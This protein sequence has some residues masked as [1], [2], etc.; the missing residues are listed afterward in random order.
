M[1]A[2]AVEAT[3]APAVRQVGVEAMVAV[4]GVEAVWK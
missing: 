4:G 1:L 3:G 2:I